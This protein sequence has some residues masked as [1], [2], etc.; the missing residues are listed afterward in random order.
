M[1]QRVDTL[2][3]DSFGL[4]P[5]GGTSVDAAVVVSPVRLGGQDYRVGGGSV[6]ARID[7]S[8]TTSGYVFR[9]R[10]DAPLEGPCMRCL[11]DAHPVVAVDIREVDQP[12]EAEDLHLSL[13]HI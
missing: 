1:A 4:A 12:G 11:K 10:F 3:L 2:D 9:L 8:R 13:I 6:D 5:G 7:I